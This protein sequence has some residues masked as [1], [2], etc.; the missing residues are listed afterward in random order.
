METLLNIRNLV[1]K[2]EK[3]IILDLPDLSI[4]KGEVL[5]VLGPNG[6]GKSTLLLTAAG[7]LKPTSG[8]VQFA[9]T[10]H[11][12]DLEYR[13][14]VSTVFQTPLLLSDNVENNIASGLRFRGMH[15]KEIDERVRTWMEL[16]H[17]SHLAK[18]R[19][20]SLSGG[21]AQRVSL[22]RAFCLQT[23]LILMDEPFSALDAPT[24]QELLD[25]LRNIFKK[26][27]QT[28]IYVTHDLEEALSIGDRVVVLFKGKI[29][30]ISQ[31]QDVFLHPAT[32][33]VAEF[34]GVGN[35]IPGKVINR[36]DELLQ[37]Q[38]DHTLVE[39]LG[40]IPVGTQVFV[41]LRP[42]DITLYNSGQEMKLSTARNHLSCRITHII[43]QGSFMRIQ[44]E[45]GFSL[46][47]LVTRLSAN[48]MKLEVGKEVTAVFKAT[49][50]HLISSGRVQ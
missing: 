21:E 8:S 7:L 45:S 26:T 9:Q 50:I 48:E 4:N 47:A 28:C 33:Q 10:S 44:L 25:D 19:A 38:V 11:L 3:A 35:I 17:I 42:E 37:I 40:N 49:A 36:E 32:P 30:Q 2:A 39:A 15:N 46:S 18:R 20:K 41:C 16:L 6:A 31:A 5:V 34:M 22:A 23:E 1:V 12:S 29:H 24:R 13:R 43:N 27:N 14:K